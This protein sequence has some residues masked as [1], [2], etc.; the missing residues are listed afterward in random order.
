[1]K[2]TSFTF[3]CFT[4]IH[5]SLQL[6]ATEIRAQDYLYPTDEEIDLMI[7]S[8]WTLYGDKDRRAMMSYMEQYD[9]KFIAN[10][11]LRLDYYYAAV[12]GYGHLEKYDLEFESVRAG[13]DLAHELQDKWMLLSLYRELASLHAYSLEDYEQAGKYFKKAIQFIDHPTVAPDSKAGLLMDYGLTLMEAGQLDSAEVYYRRS[14]EYM[15]EV[16]ETMQADI[17]SFYIPYLLETNQFDSA[18]YHLDLASAYWKTNGYRGAEMEMDIHYAD[19]AARQNNF[20]E[21]LQ[22]AISAAKIADEVESLNAL[23]DA[24][25]YKAEAE[26]Q[27]GLTTASVES[28]SQLQVVS[29]TLDKVEAAFQIDKKRL[30][31]VVDE[32][33]SA[34]LS[35]NSTNQALKLRSRGAMTALVLGIGLIALFTYGLYRR[36]SIKK[37]E[38]NALQ[39][40]LE[41]SQ[42]KLDSL[43]MEYR[44][45]IEELQRNKRELTSSAMFMEKKD[46]TLK[47]IRKLLGNLE[48]PVNASVAQTIKTARRLTDS[49]I[50][51]ESSWES[52]RYFFDQVYPSFAE[53]LKESQPKLNQ[54]DLRSLSYL[55]MGLTDKESARL[56]GINTA[57]FQKAKYRLKKKMELPNGQTIRDWLAEMR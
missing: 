47:T 51:T 19:L 9:P 7:D 28:Y 11:T 41:L 22:Y 29:D 21:S 40:Q 13:L 35:A 2:V 6:W 32:Y 37:N 33:E 53:D 18:K 24:L 14:F 16:N 20:A 25:T 5:L 46:E 23:K 34:L 44:D 57:S 54:N 1:M 8:A 56:L 4:F 27:L 50:N 45:T 43:K 38:I 36:N 39:S 15:S 10:D 12:I 30:A 26:K 52:F 49:S 42:S 17:R 48:L 3:L 31:F 55:K